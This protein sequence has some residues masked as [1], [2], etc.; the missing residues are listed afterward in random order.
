LDLARSPAAEA[1][2]SPTAEQAGSEPRARTAHGAS[3]THWPA[4]DGLRGIA[5]LLVMAYHFMPWVP[6]SRGF[7]Y[8]VPTLVQSGWCGVDLFFVLS[9]FLITGLLAGSQPSL[10]TLRNFYARRVLRI[11][12]LCWGVLVVLFVI[13]PALGWYDARAIRGHEIWYWTFTANLPY[14]RGIEQALHVPWFSLDHF[15]S[16]AVEEQLYLLWPWVVLHVERRTALTLCLLLGGLSALAR[17]EHV[18]HTPYDLGGYF[19]TVYRV[20]AFALG[21]SLALCERTRLVPAARV[22]AAGCLGV[23]ASY[24]VAVGRLDYGDPWVQSVGF[25]GLALLAACMIVLAIEVPQ[26]AVA[27]LCTWGPLR[28]VGKHSYGLYIFHYVLYASY[29]RWMHPRVLEAWLGPLGSLLGFEAASMVATLAVTVVVYHL[30]ERPF[31]HLKRYFDNP[32]PLAGP[33]PTSP[34]LT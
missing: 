12:P 18:V 28:F 16:L 24:L 30:Y 20:D 32:A 26:S 6:D 10:R 29:L 8:W 27:R 3:T 19:F 7:G 9:G 5:I 33:T 25:T 34:P 13:G 21:G 31:V 2:A 4:L 23:G 22:V 17:V 11:V 15:W 14:V 1:T